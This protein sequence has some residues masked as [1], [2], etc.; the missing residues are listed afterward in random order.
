MTDVLNLNSSFLADYSTSSIDN[1]IKDYYQK[2]CSY[3]SILFER[4]KKPL[5]PFEIKGI[6]TN[7]PINFFENSEKI[8]FEIK[9]FKNELLYKYSILLDKQFNIIYEINKLL[10]KLGNSFF[11][12]RDLLIYNINN[13]KKESINN[14]I[15]SDNIKIKYNLFLSK[16]K[17]DIKRLNFLKYIYNQKIHEYNDSCNYNFISI[18]NYI[19]EINIFVTNNLDDELSLEKYIKYSILRALYYSNGVIKNKLTDLYECGRFTTLFVLKDSSFTSIS[20]QT[21]YELSKLFILSKVIDEENELI[22]GYDFN[23]QVR[24]FN[25]KDIIPIEGY[26]KKVKLEFPSSEFNIS[27]KELQVINQELKINYPE[28]YDDTIDMIEQSKKIEIFNKIEGKNQYISKK[29][30]TKILSEKVLSS[31]SKNINTLI[32][33]SKIIINKLSLSCN[34]SDTFLIS[35]NHSFNFYQLNN[36]QKKINLEKYVFPEAVKN[37]WNKMLSNFYCYKTDNNKIIPIFI[38][39]RQ[40]SSVQHYYVYSILKNKKNLSV[41]DLKYYYDEAEKCIYPNQ[42][43]LENPYILNNILKRGLIVKDID[44]TLDKETY[45]KG[46]YAKIN[47]ISII[48]NILKNTLDACLINLIDD[49]N[50]NNYSYDNIL[51]IVRDMINKNMVPSYY[52]N[53]DSDLELFNNL[54][55][56]IN[57]NSDVSISE[58]KNYD[59]TGITLDL[60]S[61][62]LSSSLSSE[63]Q[64]E[65]IKFNKKNLGNAGSEESKTDLDDEQQ[66]LLKKFKQQ[67]PGKTNEDVKQESV[68]KKGSLTTVDLQE[69]EK[70][71]I[72]SSLKILS[73][74][75]FQSEKIPESSIPIDTYSK[76]LKDFIKETAAYL[77]SIHE[78]YVADIINL[79]K[80]INQKYSTKKIMEIPPDGDC[81]YY[82][83][84]QLLKSKNLLVM[85]EI[86]SN[87]QFTFSLKADELIVSIGK[88]SS[89]SLILREASIQLRNLV[90]NKI[91]SNKDN[92]IIK[93]S[94]IPDRVIEDIDVSN[95]L[96]SYISN[97]RNSA[98]PLR[99]NIPAGEW[100]GELEIKIISA[101]LNLDIYVINSNN[102]PEIMYDSKLNRTDLPLGNQYNKETNSIYLGYLNNSKHY[103]AIIDKLEE[104]ESQQIFAEL[105][106]YYYKYKDI[107]YVIKISDTE[108]IYSVIGIYQSNNNKISYIE[109]L[110]DEEINK[111]DIIALEENFVLKKTT[112]D[113]LELIIYQRDINNDTVYYNGSIIGKYTPQLKI[114]FS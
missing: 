78:G 22:E 14:K 64:T 103:I 25:L 1:E 61:N 38:D 107:N 41:V 74:Y 65:L 32:K 77:T 16:Y 75:K 83:V 19:D 24:T 35:V 108:P 104:L 12:E 112:E 81:F 47:Q 13:F 60:N 59:L 71:E 114:D 88:T 10:Q 90:A 101:L 42:Y 70:Q 89:T 94:I 58:R 82:S 63:P 95:N 110:S 113:N 6:Q 49:K 21:N 43:S 36:N 48:R 51:M 91:L 39:G 23:A 4:K 68:S 96:N 76:S 57:S 44:L 28:V 67:F 15:D 8:G 100:G 9:N 45:I 53:I 52:K 17:N 56:S 98:S 106:Y 105:K 85:N 54:Y 26:K 62:V 30:K 18:I 93:N 102:Q 92:I 3:N 33:S 97:V 84:V 34:Q 7:Y 79:E 40:F 86:S 37:T 11:I 109:D 50:I 80:I 29:I 2:K 27:I 31:S 20:K 69:Y 66:I 111:S 5:L 72:E 55:G 99:G 87:E 46:V 73:K